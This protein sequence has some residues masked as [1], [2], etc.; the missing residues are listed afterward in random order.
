MKEI[1]FVDANQMN[2]LEEYGAALLSS[3]ISL[4]TLEQFHVAAYKKGLLDEDEVECSKTICWE[5]RRLVLLYKQQIENIM[6][7]TPLN[8]KIVIH[9][10]KAMIPNIKIPKKKKDKD[11]S[12]TK[13]NRRK[14]RQVDTK[15]DE[16]SS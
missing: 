9:N 11:G 8:E 14:D 10:L 15:D 3:I 2:T 1:K 6:E 13:R 16:V 4:R 7:R 12:P 5:I